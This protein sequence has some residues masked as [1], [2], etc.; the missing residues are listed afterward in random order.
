MKMC[1]QDRHQVFAIHDV[2]PHFAMVFPTPSSPTR[3]RFECDTISIISVRKPKHTAFSTGNHYCE[4]LE[5]TD[6]DNSW[7]V[8]LSRMNDV[9]ENRVQILKVGQSLVWAAHV[10]KLPSVIRRG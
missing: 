5:M 6:G 3:R 4:E 8:Y 7:P 9:E 2:F 1:P 10:W